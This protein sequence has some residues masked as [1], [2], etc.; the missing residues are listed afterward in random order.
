VSKGCLLNP[1]QIEHEQGWLSER[2]KHVLSEKE[3]LIVLKSVVDRAPIGIALL[4]HDLRYLRVNDALCKMTGIAA[5]TYL[6]HTLQEVRPAIAP[7]IEPVLRRV[8]NTGEQFFDIEIDEASPEGHH[9]WSISCYPIQVEDTKLLGVGMMITNIT[10]RKHYVELLHRRAIQDAFRVT[11][12][13]ALRPLTDPSEI[14]ST[15]AQILGRQLAV[16]RVNYADV[17]SERDV[18]IVE[19]GYVNGVSPVSGRYTLEEYGRNLSRDHKSGQTMIEP[20]VANS[21]HLTDEQKNAFKAL[22]IAAHIDV[23]LVKNKQFVGLLFVHQAKPRQWTDDEV[24]LVEETAERTWEAVERA[25]SQTALREG[26]ERYRTL[27]NSIDEGFCVIEVLFDEQDKPV[28]YRFLEI[29]RVFEKQTGLVDAVG[30]R[31]RELVPEHEEHWFQIYGRIVRTGKPERFE[32]EAKYL[33]DRYYDVYAFPYR[34]NQVGILFNDI[35]ARKQAEQALRESQLLLQR[36]LSIDT[37]GVLFFTLDGHVTAVNEAFA[38]MTGYSRDELLNITHWQ[39]LTP[40]EFMDVTVRAKEELAAQGET[41]PYEKQLIRKDGSRCWGLFAPKRLSGIG[42]SSQCVEFILDITERKA[43]EDQLRQAVQSR[44]EFLSVAAHELRTPVT[45]LRGFAQTL[46]R[47]L[48]KQQIIDPDRLKKNLERIDQQS[49]KL[50]V[51]IGQ[52][53]DVSRLEAGRLVLDYQLTDLV[54]L[55]RSVTSMIQ[56]E[57]EQHQLTIDAPATLLISIDPIRIEQVLVN[58]LNN[59][60]KYSPGGGR[61]DIRIYDEANQAYVSV[62]DYGLGIPAERRPHIFERFYQGHGDGYLGGMGIGLYISCQIAELHG[63]T[64]ITEFPED[65][66]TRIILRLPYT[67]TT[68]N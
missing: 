39:M 5:T 22:D 9:H 49:T 66:S 53:L 42:S 32:N 21:P 37:V 35:A 57:T 7:H 13:D 38:R 20:D 34:D 25:R 60:V 11:L 56:N 36:A 19:I 51:L 65:A 33:G 55:V 64:I 45:S 8:L 29:N 41:A 6:G 14:K 4:D 46:L 44:D 52:L 68:S 1:E 12:S 54:A 43:A 58:L 31:I 61:I 48:N 50:G 3:E 28:D 47:Q 2:S 30:K 16:N 67:P 62:T 59:A 18:V 24:A 26:E 27:F 17:V 23:P 10:E 40:P 63:G 15:A